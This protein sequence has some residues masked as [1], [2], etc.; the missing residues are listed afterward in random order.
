[1]KTGMSTDLIEVRARTLTWEAEGVL[2]VE[3]VRPDGAALPAFEAGAHVDLHLPLPSGGLT[4]SYSLSN[5]PGETHRYVLGIG[6][7]R[8]SRGGSR[9]VHEQLRP[10]ALL[11]IGAPRNH[12]QLNEA[13]PAFAL[14]AGGI[15]VTP[16][17]AMARR[18]A[19]L[20]KPVKM[21]YAVRNAAAAAFL[22]E[23]RRLVPDLT[24]H[25]DAQA[26]G[27]PDL[28]GWLGRLPQ[29]TGAY[30]CG[31][32]PM[33]DTFEAACAGLGLA[34]A[35]I[36]RFA[37]APA[38]AEATAACT[39]V[40]EKT[41][42]SVEV[43]AG[44]SILQA[45]LDQKIDVPYSCMEGVCGSCETRVLAGEI[46]HR[47]GLLSAAEKARGDVMMICVSGCKGPRLVLD[48]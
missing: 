23:L 46:D 28:A 34:D 30:C 20:G 19:A 14:V 33:L 22:D 35:H 36:E 40:L 8:A 13:A 9:W 17:L 11:K 27:P 12:F 6:L 42:R 21:L 4:R 45:L 47:D 43:K 18:L 15:G 7:D 41:G 10:G 44:T 37:A 38:P 26:G 3:L 39:V 25:L 2:S 29:D 31:P 48:L 16:I 24:L 32:A 5:A 1:M